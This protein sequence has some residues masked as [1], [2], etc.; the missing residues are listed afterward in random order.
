MRIILFNNC[1][2]TEQC[3]N[4]GTY[5]QSI[6][7]ALTESGFEVDICAMQKTGYKLLDYLHF[8]CSLAVKSLPSDTVLY[9]NHYVFLLPLMFRL[10]FLHR[11]CVFHWHGEELISNRII[12]RCSRW[13]MIRTFR[14]DAIHISPSEYYTS[15]IS[16]K[17]GISKSK[18][19]ISPSGGVDTTVF[20]GDRFLLG[21]N[22]I[23]HIGYSAPLN[24]H[25]GVQFFMELLDYRGKLEKAINHKVHFHVI[26]YGNELNTFNQFIY[27]KQISCITLYPKF[28][29]NEMPA[30]Y[31]QIHLLL[32]LSKR[33][34]LG[35]TVLESMACNVPVLARNIC[36]M[37]EM[38]ISEMTGELVS[39]VPTINELIEKLVFM[40]C[41]LQ[42]YN[43]RKFIEKYYSKE[44]I[45]S[46]FKTLFKND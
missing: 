19:V 29:K 21:D 20:C 22:D 32:F 26:E 18:I 11:R 34:S 10:F 6:A 3:P 14:T 35:L 43:P 5:V 30:F 46:N 24:R 33:E 1:Y 8:Y 41:H 16:E 12:I 45:V 31:K 44:D 38:V 36:S 25:K 40:V 17:L 39:E 13:L 28:K 2:P 7:E 37:P 9:I 27:K 23:L 15:V 42:N 4:E